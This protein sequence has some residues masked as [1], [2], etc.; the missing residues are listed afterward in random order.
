MTQTNVDRINRILR[1]KLGVQNVAGLVREAMK[2]HLCDDWE[3]VSGRNLPF[4]S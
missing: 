2:R 4:S 1:S 3:Q